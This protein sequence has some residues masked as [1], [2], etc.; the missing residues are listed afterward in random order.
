[1]V[2]VAQKAVC[3]AL[4]IPIA[5]HRIHG[6]EHG[7]WID[8]VMARN[9]DVDIFLIIDVDCVPL[10]KERV[11]ENAQ[12]AG[13]GTLVGAEGAANHLDPNRSYAGAWYTFIGRNMWRTLG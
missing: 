6:L 1:M 8:W 9:E 12:K 13:T 7:E 3:D 2:P 10:N 5:Q 11:F 4:Q